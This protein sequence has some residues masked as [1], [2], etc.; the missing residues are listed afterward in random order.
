MNAP[1]L[2]RNRVIVDG[3]TIAIT[4]M[5]TAI[6]DDNE[7]F[8]PKVSRIGGGEIFKYLAAGKIF[9]SSVELAC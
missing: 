8:R 7:V 6:V 9:F 5:V 2:P 1:P 4:A 3:D